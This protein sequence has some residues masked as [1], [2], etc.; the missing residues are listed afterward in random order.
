M[1]MTLALRTRSTAERP[2]ARPRSGDKVRD[3]ARATIV[4]V[5]ERG[6]AAASIA[7][8]AGRADVGV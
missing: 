8:I 2:M 6:F 3:I 4:E 7:G 5:V 1:G